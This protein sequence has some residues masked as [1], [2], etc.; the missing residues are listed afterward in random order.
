MTR[1][2]GL[3]FGGGDLRN[4]AFDGEMA[5]LPELKEFAREHNLKIGTIADLIEYRSARE[6][7]VERVGQ[8]TMQTAVGE[9]T[10]VP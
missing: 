2:A 9:F 6:K 10:A 7:L 4:H 8:Y 5:R 3:T 1:L